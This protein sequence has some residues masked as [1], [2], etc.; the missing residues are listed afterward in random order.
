MK[1]LLILSIHFFLLL[2]LNA[3]ELGDSCETKEVKKSY[4]K[5][6]DIYKKSDIAYNIALC[7]ENISDSTAK[8]WFNN[9]IQN[10]KDNLKRDCSP[11]AE[12]QPI[13]YFHIGM[14]YFY[15]EGDSSDR[16]IVWLEKAYNKY[17]V[18]EDA[19]LNYPKYTSQLLYTF[20]KLCN[21]H[22]MYKEAIN[23]LTSFQEISEDKLD[24]QELI[25]LAKR[26]K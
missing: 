25:E 1:Y 17:K 24:S 11:L 13:V 2:D 19:L 16:A 20:G 7:Y 12:I 6:K 18:D 10:Y 22:E 15:L 3:Q 4:K 9:V 26:K 23:S 21:T 5:T 8:P 14:S